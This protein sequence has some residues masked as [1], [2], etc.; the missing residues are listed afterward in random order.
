MSETRTTR[1]E[2]LRATARGFTLAGLVA[3]AAL[4]LHRNGASDECPP[5]T[6]CANCRLR[7]R[8][9]RPE[10]R[11]DPSLNHDLIRGEERLKR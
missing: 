7:D 3:G 2:L 5:R 6:V 11:L 9:E 4:L 8:C 1:R 10:K